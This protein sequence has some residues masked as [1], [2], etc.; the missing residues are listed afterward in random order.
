MCC[1]QTLYRG[2]L[3]YVSS[4]AR[5]SFDSEQESWLQN[6]RFAKRYDQRILAHKYI[7]NGSWAV[8]SKSAK[9]GHVPIPIDP[10]MWYIP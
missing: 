7:L 1:P 10:A 3:W 8:N 2:I 9:T 6:E 4:I 5:E